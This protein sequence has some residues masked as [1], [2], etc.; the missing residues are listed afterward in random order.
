MFY[1]FICYSSLLL[2]SSCTST[3]KPA[4]TPV[5]L[6]DL[7]QNNLILLDNNFENLPLSLKENEIIFLGEIHKT[8]QMIH[9]GLMLAINMANYKPVV[10]ASESNYGYGLFEEAASLGNPKPNIFKGWGNK[11]IQMPQCIQ[12]FNSTQ[13]IDRKILLTAVDLEHSVY[14]TKSDMVI[15]LK[16]L[17]G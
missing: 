16:E 17:A 10:H 5:Q 15:I 8:P 2:L 13:T 11:P 4:I 7:L 14:H 1:R 6:H 9:A 3:I 12:T